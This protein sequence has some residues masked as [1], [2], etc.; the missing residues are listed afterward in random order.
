VAQRAAAGPDEGMKYFR[1]W[2]RL[3]VMSFL[4]QTESFISSFGYLLG[5]LVRIGFFLFFLFSIFK[6]TDALAGYSL[7]EVAL[8]FLTFNIVDI[9]AQLFF[10]GV[11]GI[12]S[13]I[14]EGDFDY[15][16]IQPANVLFRVAFQTVDFLDVVT[17]LPVFA[18]TFYL[19]RRIHME[20]PIAHF[21]LYAL[22]TLNGLVIAFAIHIAVASLAV[23]TQE[24]ENTIWIYRDLMTLG[25]FPSDIY[26]PPMRAILT[27][28][29]PVAVM[30]SFPA[31]AFLGR[32]S[33]AWMI[34]AGFMAMT[35]LALSLWF[36]TFSIRRYTSVS[37]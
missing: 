26:D 36:W 7:Q 17:I 30:V 11:Y 8:F 33:P 13:L 5:K 10:R 18:I 28:V 15:F 31:K 25:R 24:L 22:L 23:L 9:L 3:A 19:F 14:R 16:L 35:S 27:F 32:L 1:V 2:R 34:Q 12:R 4:L 20:A 21:F 6:H 29:V 37:S